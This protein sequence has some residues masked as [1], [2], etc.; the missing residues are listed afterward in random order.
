[1]T[2]NI[3]QPVPVVSIQKITAHYEWNK[4]VL[5]NVSL[6]IMPGERLVLLGE[7]GSG[8]S[9]LLSCISGIKMP[10]KGKILFNGEP[11]RY[12]DK[13]LQQHWRRVPMID[14]D[15]TSLIEC[16]TIAENLVKAMII[17]GLPRWTAKEYAHLYLE[18]VGLCGKENAY[19]QELSGGQRQRAVIC[20]ALAIG[21][22]MEGKVLLADEP[23]SSLDP[24]TAREIL[25]LLKRL[26]CAVCLITHH[27]DRVI[28]F[29]DRMF[30]LDHR[31]HCLVDI[32]NVK[33]EHPELLS[34]FQKY[35]DLVDESNRLRIP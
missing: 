26:R 19:P 2:K 34:N 25:D 7:T 16:H 24:P 32:T 17:N 22:N 18:E 8:K 21:G 23:V 35:S 31:H 4:P 6:N 10:A 28:D 15:A 29:C 14:Q 12:R 9:T 30:L 5:C 33:K 27:P 20:K 13:E 1:M 11:L 3:S